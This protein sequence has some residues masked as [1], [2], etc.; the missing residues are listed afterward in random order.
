MVEKTFVK[1]TEVEDKIMMKINYLIAP[2]MAS[3]DVTIVRI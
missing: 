2:T 1:K 3:E